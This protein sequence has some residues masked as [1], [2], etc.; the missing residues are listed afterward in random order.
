VSSLLEASLESGKEVSC[1][2]HSVSPSSSIRCSKASYGH[3][4]HDASSNDNNSSSSLMSVGS[5][6]ASAAVLAA[7]LAVSEATV[8]ATEAEAVA[9]AWAKEQDASLESTESLASVAKSVEDAAW[10]AAR[11]SQT[12]AERAAAAT[13]AAS[14]VHT[15]AS[16]VEEDSH[17]D[18]SHTNIVPRSEESLAWEAAAQRL[19]LVET[20]AA[21]TVQSK[22][23]RPYSLVRVHPQ[24]NNTPLS[25]STLFFL[26]PCLR[27][28]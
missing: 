8:E 24:Y 5:E 23:S 1:K 6:L 12:A 9:A 2:Q 28:Y 27:R 21:L 20:Q 22:K 15:S 26:T 25:T 7:E 19:L 13:A 18:S 14:S 11:A 10:A 17:S 4:F 16:V 3:N